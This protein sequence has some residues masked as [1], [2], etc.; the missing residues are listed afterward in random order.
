MRNIRIATAVLAF[1]TALPLCAVPLQRSF[2]SAATGSDANPCTRTAPCRNF[3]AA[4]AVTTPDGE[5]VA[6]DSGGYGS[7]VISQAVSIEAPLG[8]VAAVTVFSGT[9]GVDITASATQ[10]VTVRGLTIN[11]LGGAKGIWVAG[12]KVVTIDTCKLAG[13]MD[14]GVFAQST[15]PTFILD[16]TMTGLQLAAVQIAP[17]A[18]TP[19]VMERTRIEGQQFM[20]QG[21]Q[22]IGAGRMVI[23]DSLL[24]NC[25][26]GLRAYSPISGQTAEVTVENSLI[27]S[28]ALAILT[29][30]NPGGGQT[31]VR[32]A[33]STITHNNYGVG[34]G[35][36][37]NAP[38]ISRGDN[39]LAANTT[40][41]AFDGTF[42]PQ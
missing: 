32:V 7:F 19:V 13:A 36:P 35:D 21:V 34:G 8:I 23:R 17:S 24:L 27:D 28:N 1:V 4:I 16:S 18:P 14:Y 12:G 29:Q 30:F 5:V 40:N 33:N 22:V 37:A 39:T 42:A 38:V 15:T 6:L 10:I 2:V 9:D 20:S 11:G 41:G 3:A 31:I 25:N 26:N